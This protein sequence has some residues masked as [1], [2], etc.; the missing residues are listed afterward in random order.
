[1]KVEVLRT[2]RQKIDVTTRDFPG[3]SEGKR[4][5]LYTHVKVEFIVIIPDFVLEG[6]IGIPYKA[7][8]SVEEIEA[9]IL[10]KLIQSLKIKHAST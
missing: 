7:N 4:D 1:M 5:Y 6:E 9:M 10:K 3:I 8:Q 2:E